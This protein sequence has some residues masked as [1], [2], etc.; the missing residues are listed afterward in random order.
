MAHLSIPRNLKS[1]DARWLTEALRSTATLSSRQ[2]V[3]GAILAGGG[4]GGLAGSSRAARLVIDVD[5]QGMAPRS[6]FAKLHPAGIGRPEGDPYDTPGGREVRFFRDL[7]PGVPLPI[8]RCYYADYDASRGHFLL[9]LQ[10]L[11][12]L[13]PGHPIEG[14]DQRAA[15]A[16]IDSVARLHA[17]FW[18]SPALRGGRWPEHRYSLSEA[19]DFGEAFRRAW[20]A[21]RDRGEWPVSPSVRRLGERL[22]DELPDALWRLSRGPRTLVHRDL[23]AE[24]L[25]LNYAGGGVEVYVLDWQSAAYGNPSLDFAYAIAGDTRAEVQ[26]T[27]TRALLERYHAG[28][29][30]HAA[31]YAFEEL[32][33]DYRAAV[34]WMFAGQVRWLHAF[35]PSTGMEQQGRLKEWRRLNAAVHLLLEQSEG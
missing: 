24:N 34:T 26:K 17:H 27:H 28:L 25:G 35:Q 31:G 6:L 20:P 22:V 29:G 1:I 5:P 32:L 15:E 11:S 30:Q 23:H 33:E 4:L 3:T 2:A 9:L 19:R 18:D 10:D 16:V 8:P 12:D 13:D 21:V 7:A 14:L